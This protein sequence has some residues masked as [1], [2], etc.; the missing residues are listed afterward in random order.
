MPSLNHVFFLCYIYS[1]SKAAAKGTNIIIKRPHRGNI[2][3]TRKKK[4]GEKHAKGSQERT[5][6]QQQ[7]AAAAL[8]SLPVFYSAIKSIVYKPQVHSAW[9]RQKCNGEWWQLTSEPMLYSS[10]HSFVHLLCWILV[11]NF[12]FFFFSDF[13]GIWAAEEL[14]QKCSMVER[15]RALGGRNL[16]GNLKCEDALCLSAR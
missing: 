15:V 2:K 6:R 14:Y 8:T 7:A 4:T 5:K 3:V 12:F 11:F 13:R 10:Q 1:I 9:N 16:F